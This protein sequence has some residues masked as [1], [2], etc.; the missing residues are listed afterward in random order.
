MNPSEIDEMARTLRDTAARQRMHKGLARELMAD[1]KAAAQAERDRRLFDAGF[2]A[3]L[4]SY[5]PAIAQGVADSIVSGLA[6]KGML[7]GSPR[8][9]VKTVKR[10]K[11]TG[12]IKAVV[13][14]PQ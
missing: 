9:T 11:K 14:T 10:D 5:G 2:R 12:L 13:E 4:E 3:A 7:T 8:V 6:A 1:M